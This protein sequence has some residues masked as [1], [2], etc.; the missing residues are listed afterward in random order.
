LTYQ[1]TKKKIQLSSY[2]TLKLSLSFKTPVPRLSVR[3]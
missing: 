1:R 3:V 2:K